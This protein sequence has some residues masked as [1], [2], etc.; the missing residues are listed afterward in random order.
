MS[1]V[2][3]LSP[4]AAVAFIF[5]SYLL[6]F[7]HAPLLASPLESANSPE[8][9]CLPADN[10][11]VRVA[12][13]PNG[14]AEKLILSSIYAA[15]KSI[16]VAAYAFTSKPIS[17]ALLE[18]K[19][20]GVE[21][22]VIADSKAAK[23][24]YSALTFLAN[25]GVSVRLDEKYAIFHHKF[26]INDG[27]NVQTGSFN[28]SSAAANKNAENVVLLENMPQVALAYEQEWQLLWSESKDL[29]PAY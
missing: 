12:F 14:Q 29:P 9:A 24:K 18:A 19:K 11:C 8:K 17:L 20:K 6:L 10:S 4:R 25:Q 15:K 5:L 7:S 1:S 26:M 3:L 23:G 28:Y 2:K 13:S 16:K 21:V 27:E 22:K